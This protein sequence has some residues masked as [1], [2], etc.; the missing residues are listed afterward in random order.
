MIIKSGRAGAVW[1]DWPPVEDGEVWCRGPA[2][3]DGRPATVYRLVNGQWVAG[4]GW[5]EWDGFDS[6]RRGHDALH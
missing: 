6:E 5:G 3:D 2:M 4:D 1:V